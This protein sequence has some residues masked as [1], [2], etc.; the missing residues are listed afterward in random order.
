MVNQNRI[1]SFNIECQAK[2][3]FLNEVERTVEMSAVSIN[4]FFFC[5]RTYVVG[6]RCN[7]GYVASH[8]LKGC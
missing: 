8:D 6:T 7:R 1:V 3:F 2:N 5:S 4:I